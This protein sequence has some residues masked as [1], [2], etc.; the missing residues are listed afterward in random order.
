M[1]IELFNEN[2]YKGKGKGE[3]RI[4]YRHTTMLWLSGSL[5]PLLESD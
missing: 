4:G 2:M 5:K 1:S 3:V